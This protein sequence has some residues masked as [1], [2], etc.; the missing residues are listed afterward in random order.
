MIRVFSALIITH[1]IFLA[2]TFVFGL[3]VHD[4]RSFEMHFTLGLFIALYTCFVHSVVY[5]YFIATG[6]IAH[7]GVVEAKMDNHFLIEQSRLKSK[8]FR[9]VMLAAGTMLIAVFWGAYITNLPN[10]AILDSSNQTIHF[11]LALVTIAANLF[12]YANEHAL[13][14]ANGRLLD[15]LFD[16]HNRRLGKPSAGTSAPQ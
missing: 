1:S 9:V 15:E 4:Q 10:G 8:V 12:A 2:A 13:I 5:T 6:R 14:R 16:D 7:A 3:L 11:A